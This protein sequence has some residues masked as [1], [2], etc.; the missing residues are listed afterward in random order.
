V[1]RFGKELQNG[2][3]ALVLIYAPAGPVADCDDSK[4]CCVT[5]RIRTTALLVRHR[6]CCHDVVQGLARWSLLKGRERWLASLVANRVACYRTVILSPTAAHVR[7]EEI[8]RLCRC[9]NAPHILLH[10]PGSAGQL[11]EIILSFLSNFTFAIVEAGY[12][13]LQLP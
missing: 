12:Q 8:T 2:G 5:N 13:S 1:H 7:R 6:L 10:V 4:H 3:S 9:Q 11:V